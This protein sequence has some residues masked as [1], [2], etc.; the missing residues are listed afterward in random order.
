MFFLDL[1]VAYYSVLT[2]P[3]YFRFIEA[4]TLLVARRVCELNTGI[5]WISLTGLLVSGQLVS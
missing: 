4:V 5:N 3:I 1:T 2:N